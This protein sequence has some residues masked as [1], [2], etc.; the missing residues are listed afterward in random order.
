[1]EKK[2]E[3][4]LVE[5]ERKSKKYRLKWENLNIFEKKSKILALRKKMA[6]IK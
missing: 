6:I 2:A 1:M 5:V 3:P 4:N